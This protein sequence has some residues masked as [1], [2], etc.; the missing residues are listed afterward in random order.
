MDA[1]D[2]EF[3]PAALELLETP[4]S[5]IRVA[6]IWLICTA[7]ATALAWSYLGWLDIH[8][9]ARGRI[10]PSGRSKIVHPLEAGKV[11]AIAVE[12]GSRVAGGDVLV[13]LDPTETGADREAL[14]RELEI[15]ASGGGTPPCG[16]CCR[17]H[18]WL[19]AARR[20]VSRRHQRDHSPTRGKCACR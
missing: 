16:C 17:R 18:Q 2:R 1:V 13:E 15:D 19:E 14:S 8:A 9:I 4:P 10:Q 7:F 11:I 5:P 20:R 3:L 12:N 6:A